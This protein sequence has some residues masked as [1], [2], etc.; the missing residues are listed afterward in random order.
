[1][2][3]SQRAILAQRFGHPV[4]L[5]ILQP[6]ACAAMISVQWYSFYLHLTGQRSWK[7]RSSSATA[8]AS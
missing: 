8:V 5:A 1:L 6:L 7:G 2:G 3:A 4:S